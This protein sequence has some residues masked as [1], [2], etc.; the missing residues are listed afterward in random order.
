[1]GL[2]YYGPRFRAALQGEVNPAVL[3]DE[4][5]DP[6]QDNNVQNVNGGEQMEV[7]NG[8]NGIEVLAEA[9]AIQ[10]DLHENDQFEENPEGMEVQEIQN[11]E[12]VIGLAAAPGGFVGEMLD[13]EGQNEE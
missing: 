1:M 4:V 11:M 9:A 10:N 7:G 3:A 12:I 5:V 8:Q 13:A 6:P 2:G